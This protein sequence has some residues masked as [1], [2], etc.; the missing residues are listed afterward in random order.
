MRAW[1]SVVL[2]VAA[3]VLGA[4]APAYSQEVVTT[5]EGDV[6]VRLPPGFAPVT[7][8]PVAQL[9]YADSIQSAFL[10]VIVEPKD[11]LFGWNLTRHST[12]TS[13]QIVA[14]TDFPE[15]R[16]PMEVTVSGH[17]GIQHEVRGVVQGTQ[18]AYLQTAIEAPHAFV[19]IVMWSTR[20]RWEASE[21]LFR[22]AI[23]SVQIRSSES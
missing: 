3:L 16:G 1:S 20:S 14:V 4:T 17:P 2:G 21:P 13:A 22:E 9:Q 8:N 7:V 19:Q 6:S 18:L 10:I 15:V 5:R 11:D 12:I 23:E